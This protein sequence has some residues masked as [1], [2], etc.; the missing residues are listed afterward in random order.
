MGKQTKLDPGINKN[1]IIILI[2]ADLQ[3][4]QLISGLGSLDLHTDSYFLSLHKAVS[5]LMGVQDNQ[6]D[7]WFE[8]YDSFLENA[9]Q[10]PISDSSDHLLSVA[11]ECYELLCASIKIES[12]LN[13]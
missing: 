6:S 13:P 1:I 8:I 10:H 5:Q 2:Q 11:E 4:N 9:H 3:H 7:Q 12:H